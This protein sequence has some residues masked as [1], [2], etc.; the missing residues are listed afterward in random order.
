VVGLVL[1]GMFIIVCLFVC[2]VVG[3]IAFVVVV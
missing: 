2:K 3:L 1:A